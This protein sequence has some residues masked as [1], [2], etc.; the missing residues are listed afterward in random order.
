M[1]VAPR[2][3]CTEWIDDVSAL[4]DGEQTD[5]TAAVIE[6]HIAS[7]D[8]CASMV[9]QSAASRRSRL[10]LAPSPLDHAA[11]VHLADSVVR[12]S[13]Q[14]GRRDASFVLLGLLAVVSIQILVFSVISLVGSVDGGAIHDARHVGSFGI[15]YAAGLL[16]VVHRPA[17]ARAMLPVAAVLALALGIT[18]VIDVIERHVPL[19]DEGAHLPQLISVG[20]VWAIARRQARG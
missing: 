9:D 14:R 20:L 11:A 7:C 10:G 15:A 2:T 1:D 13:E 6:A 18:A 17:R 3:H 12:G 16:T 19:I 5:R 8:R 4:I